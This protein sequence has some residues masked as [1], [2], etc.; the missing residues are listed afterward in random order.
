MTKKHPED[1]PFN[2]IKI[3]I[4]I[5]HW[6]NQYCTFRN[7]TGLWLDY[8]R[9]SD[10]FVTMATSLIR[11]INTLHHGL[12]MQHNSLISIHN[13]WYLD[14]TIFVLLHWIIAAV[15]K[16]NMLLLISFV[17]LFSSV[18]NRNFINAL[19]KTTIKHKWRVW[20]FADKNFLFYS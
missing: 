12:I 17:D 16:P 11:Q 1:K 6:S 15:F 7:I 5:Q 9:L 13:I 20:I 4:K 8:L 19:F 14:C 10:P 2:C 3:I 18:I